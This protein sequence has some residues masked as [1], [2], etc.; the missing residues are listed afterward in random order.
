MFFLFLTFSAM[1]GVAMG[2]NYGQHSSYLGQMSTS[3]QF[4]NSNYPQLPYYPTLEPIQSHPN[5][6]SES[7]T[8]QQT[9]NGSFDADS[10]ESEIEEIPM[11]K[12]PPE[13]ITIDDSEEITP[14][15]P[16]NGQLAAMNSLNNFVGITNANSDKT[17][18][19]FLDLSKVI[20]KEK[21]DVYRANQVNQFT[22][23]VLTNNQ[24][25]P[26][27]QSGND[28]A[29]ADHLSEMNFNFLKVESNP[30]NSR[31]NP[32]PITQISHDQ[33]NTERE[34][35]ELTDLS[36][37][38][39]TAQS[40][41]LLGFLSA[42]PIMPTNFAVPV[43]DRVKPTEQSTNTQEVSSAQSTV[44]TNN[45]VDPSDD[46]M[47][48]CMFGILDE[49][50]QRANCE[51]IVNPIA[52]QPEVSNLPSIDIT[53]IRTVSD[54]RPFNLEANQQKPDSSNKNIAA[55]KKEKLDQQDQ[56]W[57]IAKP[58]RD[59][60]LNSGKT[61]NSSSEFK[62]LLRKTQ[63]KK[64]RNSEGTMKSQLTNKSITP[65]ISTPASTL[66]CSTSFNSN[67][68]VAQNSMRQLQP[69]K[70]THENIQGL[71]EYTGQTDPP[72]S[73]SGAP[74]TPSFLKPVAE[75]EK[76]ENFMQRQQHAEFE[77]QNSDSSISEGRLVICMEEN[78]SIV[79]ESSDDQQTNASRQP[80]DRTL[81]SSMESNFA[82]N[83]NHTS[84]YSY[85]NQN[86]IDN[87]ELDKS[88]ELEISPYITEEQA[89]HL[90]PIVPMQA[91]YSSNSQVSSIYSD[92]QQNN[93]PNSKLDSS[94]QRV[95]SP[96]SSSADEIPNLSPV[97]PLQATFPSN[98]HIDQQQPATS[99]TFVDQPPLLSPAPQVQTTFP[100]NLP[101]IY[102]ILNQNKMA[103]SNVDNSYQQANTQ[104]EP[105]ANQTPYVSPTPDKQ[106]SYSQNTYLLPNCTASNQNIVSNPVNSS[107]PVNTVYNTYS[108]PYTF[109]PSTMPPSNPFDN[110][111]N[112][113]PY[114]PSCMYPQTSNFTQDSSGMNSSWQPMYS[115]NTIGNSSNA[116]P[117]S[118]CMY[119]MP[120]LPKGYN[121]II[122]QGNGNVYHLQSAPPMT[123][124]SNQALSAYTPD[125]IN[126]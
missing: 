49:G 125:N 64:T 50:K 65:S 34:I 41:N 2:N 26:R 27:M 17:E 40:T 89:P 14:L 30:L 100:S 86:K 25:P 5:R 76:P 21:I 7:V 98:S 54:S 115:P 69:P 95:N 93:I 77:P 67:F 116:M 18:M 6:L 110:K 87:A 39:S 82:M 59:S 90:S 70:Q 120:P 92:P 68:T 106:A 118:S 97:F 63:P 88:Y 58:A 10:D 62:F 33:N 73:G 99:G 111:P 57:Q 84:G 107:Q 43:S 123:N 20:K 52:N 74:S 51:S 121:H 85:S 113:M 102:S 16:A 56:H 45:F 8:K 117:Q 80:S 105:V 94:Y 83:D 35:F 42:Q 24:N 37:I 47:F 126:L 114:S 28:N 66:S 101:P 91:T 36:P 78:D 55:I 71:Q 75:I 61:K 31:N 29:V 104:Y 103:V 119:P 124:W 15:E 48:A 122:S 46:T 44:P 3:T 60:S 79:T 12:E 1:Q 72:S 23:E 22:S 108:S 81:S 96:Y 19:S 9:E 109:A 38:N 53:V 32:A 4:G 11:Y 112:W 13:L